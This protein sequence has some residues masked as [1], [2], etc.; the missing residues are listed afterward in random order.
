MYT[1]TICHLRTVECILAQSVVCVILFFKMSS[2]E[3]QTFSLGLSCLFLSHSLLLHG[4]YK[5]VTLFFQ[6]NAAIMAI[7]ITILIIIIMIAL[8]T[9]MLLLQCSNYIIIDLVVDEDK[10][11]N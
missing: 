8:S 2:K 4:H 10:I 7:I 5:N 11:S 3:W 9:I 1:I 6:N